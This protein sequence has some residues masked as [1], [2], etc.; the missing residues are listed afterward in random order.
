MD[1]LRE[2]F[3]FHK[4]ATLQLVDYCAGQSPELMEKMVVGTDRSIRHTLTHIAGTE[5]WYLELLTGEA[6]QSPIRWGE[7]L[8]L[9]D[10]RERFVHESQRWERVLDRIGEIDVTIPATEWRHEIQHGQNVL[11]L[12]AIQH[13]I[14]HRTQICTTLS[15]LGLTPPHLD[16]WTYWAQAAGS[17]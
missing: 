1:L 3:H 11:V 7:V 14:D 13:G 17:K 8:E 12:Q 9:P 16:G 5:Q 6:A 2:M 4:W 15:V 10:L